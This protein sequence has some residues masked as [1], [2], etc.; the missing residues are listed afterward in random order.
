MLCFLERERSV[1]ISNGPSLYFSVQYAPFT[2][3]PPHLNMGVFLW[4]PSEAYCTHE[5]EPYPWPLFLFTSGFLHGAARRSELPEALRQ[6]VEDASSGCSLMVVWSPQP[7]SS[8]AIVLPSNVLLWAVSHSPVLLGSGPRGVDFRV[9]LSLKLSF[10]D[11]TKRSFTF[12]VS[13]FPLRQGPVTSPGAP[14]LDSLPARLCL[15]FSGS[16]CLGRMLLTG[17]PS[18]QPLAVALCLHK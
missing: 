14:R 18:L 10:L 15:Y 13:P 12:G 8:A 5:S 11:L 4:G 9:S 17:A 7:V 3:P 16:R 2:A 6:L 1:S